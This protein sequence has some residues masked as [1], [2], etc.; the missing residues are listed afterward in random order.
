MNKI[1]C[2]GRNPHPDPLPEGEGD[3]SG[4]IHDQSGFSL[5]ETLVAFS[6]LAVCLGVLLSIFGRGDFSAGLLSERA[7]AVVLAES[8]LASAL[9]E[10]PRQW[11]DQSGEID[12][13]YRWHL[14]VTPYMPLI[15]TLP[16]PVALKPYW[17]EMRVEWGDEA[18]AFS[19]G[20]LRLVPVNPS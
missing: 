7:R 19:L 1:S 13:I 17:I 6:I 9:S 2:A 16:E 4:R 10:P 11:A 14:S 12:G 18:R 5:L 3:Y 15:E 8:L 20:T